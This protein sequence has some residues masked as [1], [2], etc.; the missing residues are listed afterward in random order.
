M[1]VPKVT[2]NT[3][4]PHAAAQEM[5]RPGRPASS[6]IRSLS[7]LLPTVPIGVVRELASDARTVVYERGET[8]VRLGER[9]DLGFVVEG[10]LANAVRSNDGR[11]AMLGYL[12]PS[13]AFGVDSLYHGMT[14]TV[15]AVERTRVIQIDRIRVSSLARRHAALAL[16]L[17]QM[18]SDRSKQVDAVASEFAFMT[19]TERVLLNLLV[20]SASVASHDREASVAVTQQE[21]ADSVGS[22]REVVARA[23]RRL[24]REHLIETSPTGI[25]IRSK[26]DLYRLLGSSQLR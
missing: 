5:T 6:L 24:R 1:S 18:L 19:V 3:T 20:R 2:L 12:K 25:T 22:V 16:A 8:V 10:L 9:C 23:M 15:V 11:Q 17:C 7:A 21:L 14:H 4:V 26:M 13:A